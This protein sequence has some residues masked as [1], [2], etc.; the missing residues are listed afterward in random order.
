MARQ[1]K[2]E[3]FDLD[4]RLKDAGLVAAD[5]AAQ[6]GGADKIIDLGLGRVD[7]RVVLDTTAVEVAT[8]D[9]NY[10]I[11]TQFSASA[12]FASGVVGGPQQILGDSTTL[13]GESAD[14]P[15]VGRYELPFCNEINGTLYRY[16]RLYTDV[17][18]TIATG[19]NYVAHMVKK[20]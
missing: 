9:E 10:K 11:K 4:M 15:A 20:A 13:I 3:T 17:T 6:V 12:T 19:I 18:G 2:D 14:S 7:A 8:G 1:Q 5:A 16:M